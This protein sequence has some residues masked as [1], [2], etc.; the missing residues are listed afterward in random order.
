MSQPSIKTKSNLVTAWLVCM[1]ASLFFLY[2]FIQMNM[3]NAISEDL[4]KAFHIDATGLSRLSAFY[5]IANVVFLFPAGVLLDRCSSKKIILA[6]LAICILGT[7]LFATSHNTPLATFYRFLTGIGSA[8]CFL[9]V[10]RLATRWF[11]ASALAFVIGMVVTMAMLG[12]VIAQKPL[13][14]LV[15]AVEWRNAL[16][17]DAAIGVV[18]FALIFCFVQDYPPEFQQQLHLELREVSRLG[19]WKSLGFAFLKL[20]NWLSGIFSCLMNLPIIILGGLWGILYLEHV[21]GI[22]HTQA[23]HITQMLFFGAIVGAPLA[24][25]ISDRIG[26]RR[27]PMI[28]GG[29]FSLILVIVLV[30]LPDITFWSLFILFFLLG[31]TTSAQIISYS[32][33]AESSLPAIIAMSVSVVNISTQGGLAL[34]EP[35]FGYLMDLH[36]RFVGISGAEYVGGDFKWAMMMFA[37]G[38]ALALLA[39][40]LLRETYCLPRSNELR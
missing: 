26:L 29:L 1:V 40:C 25:W 24:G 21:Q 37:V 34:F 19:Y 38:I 11:H 28:I 30:A 36:H 2:E 20:Q 35:L 10:I 13:S 9:S 33:V 7:A 32:I 17:V 15:V 5:F 27:L 4:M 14:L 16:L 12:G 31:V 8:F 6:A 23:P 18:F 39:A 22:S 3:F